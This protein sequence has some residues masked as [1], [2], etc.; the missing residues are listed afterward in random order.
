LLTPI[1]EAE[2]SI[3][4]SPKDSRISNIFNNLSLNMPELANLNLPMLNS[5]SNNTND[6]ISIL[7]SRRMAETVIKNLKLEKNKELYDE[8]TK[9]FQAVVEK[10]QKK[11]KIFPPTG[12]DTT[13]R[14]KARFENKEIALKICNKYFYELKRFLDK[15]NFN[16]A[17][18]NRIFIEKQLNKTTQDLKIAEIELLNFKQNNKTV[19]LP[20]EVSEYIKYI[21]DLEAQELKS[22]LEIKDISERIKSASSKISDFNTE[23]QN[24]IQEMEISQNA[25]KSR[26]EILKKAKDK[27]YLLLNALPNK[28][29]FLARLERDI[30][31]KNAL[32]LMFTQQYE[33]AKIEESKE[34]E[35]F[36]ILD[37]GYINDKPVFPRKTVMTVGAF[38]VSFILSLLLAFFIEYLSKE[39]KKAKLFQEQKNIDISII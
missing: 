23:W 28:A 24:M 2:S 4:I 32:Y 31:I 20:D 33:I 3:I 15:N 35:P 1:Y 17:T 19:S 22:R 6:L 29:L 30:K 12:K 37:S 18:R 14:V 16:Q 26:E 25:M 11:V 7:R 9:T 27:Y 5:S 21:S 36:K 39:K 38:I 13:I 10:F 8:K 34:N